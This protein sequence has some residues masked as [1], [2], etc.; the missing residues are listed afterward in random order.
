MLYRSGDLMD[1]ERA[2]ARAM[3]FAHGPWWRRLLHK[4]AKTLIYAAALR[5]PLWVPF[6]R[7]VSAQTFFEEE[8]LVV[9]PEESACQLFYYGVIEEDVTAFLLTYLTEGMTF[10]DVGAHS[11]YFTLLAS[12][13]VHPSGWVHAFEPARRTCARLRHNTRRH[14]NVTI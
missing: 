11:G 8:M 9:L 4:P 5:L 2:F 6:A 12:Q 7:Q 1:L 3:T 10:I 14:R 13:L